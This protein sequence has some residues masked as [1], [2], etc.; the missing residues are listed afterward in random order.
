[1]MNKKDA[2]KDIFVYA[3]WKE[4]G[5]TK[6][7]GVLHSELLRGKEIFSFEYDQEWL[8]EEFA[9]VIDPDLNLYSGLHYLNDVKSNFGVFLDSSPDR[10]GRILM[11]RRE[12]ALARIE[13]KREAHLYETDYLLGVYDGHR[14]GGLRFKMS[15]D[16]PFLDDNKEP[17]KIDQNTTLLPN[18]KTTKNLP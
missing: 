7:M 1:M 17:E 11:R 8:Q 4:I 5:G 6:L 15:T 12:A 2:R 13:G 18:T 3:D 10:W 14:M 16:G 9:Q